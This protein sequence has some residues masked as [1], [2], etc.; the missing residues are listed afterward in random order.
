MLCCPL[1]LLLHCTRY[2][3]VFTVQRTNSN[4]ACPFY[5]KLLLAHSPESRAG[6]V[7]YYSSCSNLQ[8]A[9]KGEDFDAH[10]LLYCTPFISSLQPKEHQLSW[11]EIFASVA[12][13][14]L[15]PTSTGMQLSC[16]MCHQDWS[17]QLPYYHLAL[18]FTEGH[19]FSLHPDGR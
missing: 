3:C 5:D 19:S 10:T 4:H 17:L 2:P 14:L 6:G 15:L 12:L 9:E 16:Q 7:Q 13:L 8:K 18:G 11:S 1:A